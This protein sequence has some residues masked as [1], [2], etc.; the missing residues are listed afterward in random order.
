MSVLSP[1]E[2]PDTVIALLEVNEALLVEHPDLRSHLAEA[3]LMNGH[4]DRALHE[5]EKG[6]RL[7]PDNRLLLSNLRR[8]P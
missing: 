1:Q 3:W 6:L 2:D 5:L 4:P 8:L 7:S